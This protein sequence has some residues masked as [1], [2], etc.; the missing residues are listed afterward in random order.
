MAGLAGPQPS[1]GEA[2]PLPPPTAETDL[3]AP[4]GVEIPALP[5]AV[6]APLDLE[7]D[8]Y[9]GRFNI[10]PGPPGSGVAIEGNY[11]T[12]YYELI[13]ERDESNAGHRVE[14][15]LQPRVGV[16]ARMLQGLTNISEDH[17]NQLT[18][19]IP[20]SVP[21]RLKLTLRAGTSKVELGGLWLI[22]PDIHLAQ[23]S[24]RLSFDEPLTFDS[25]HASLR[26][27]MGEVKVRQL[28]NLRA[29]EVTTVS[30]MGAFEYDLG[31][32]WPA[33]TPVVTM[34]HGMGDLVVELPRSLRLSKD[35]NNVVMFGEINT[36]SRDRDEEAEAGGPEI[37]LNLKTKMG[38]TRIS[39]Y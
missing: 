26:T 28:G 14:V 13:E 11:A 15:R 12:K 31:G 1:A 24:H 21:I 29:S 2:A 34:Q 32:A 17:P 8:M 5:P 20:R 3:P 18:V 19:R 33:G 39:R 16:F 4:G 25:G 7:I 37:T 22:D 35:S 36:N 27:E 6:T 38:G 9:E 10:E 23:G 30:R